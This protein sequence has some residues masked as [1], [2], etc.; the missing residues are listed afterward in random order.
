M[1]ILRREPPGIDS[2]T[3]IASLGFVQPISQGLRRDVASHLQHGEIVYSVFKDDAPVG[4]VILNLV[5]DN[6]LYLS[7]VILRPEIQG[8]GV[9]RMAVEA[10][11]MAT[12]AE[13]LTLRTQSIRMW[14]AG[15]KMCAEWFPHHEASPSSEASRLA[16]QVARMTNSVFPV[17]KG[18]YGGPLYGK[19]PLH[20]DPRMNAWWDSV[21]DFGMGDAVFC[22]GR[23]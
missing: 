9:A 2:A 19:K 4:F 6:V 20:H 7:G 15:Q 18:H 12:G 1:F 8:K 17:K 3:E 11:R 10:A 21:C 5:L 23:F 14:V 16:H 22:I 13:W